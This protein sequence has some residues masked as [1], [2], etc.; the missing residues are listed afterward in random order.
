[1]R[2]RASHDDVEDGG[3]LIL[4]ERGD[5]GLKRHVMA[6]V[7]RVIPV[8]RHLPFRAR[9]EARRCFALHLHRLHLRRSDFANAQ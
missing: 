8:D 1:M 5:Q 6:G 4:S 7:D 2:A 3:K 9:E